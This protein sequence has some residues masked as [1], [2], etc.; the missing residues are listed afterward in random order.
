[1]TRLRVASFLIVTTVLFPAIA[2]AQKVVGWGNTTT[3]PDGIH[4]VRV[5]AGEN[6][7]LALLPNGSVVAW[8]NASLGQTSVPD[9]LVAKDISA[10]PDNGLALRLDGSAVAWGT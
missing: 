7:S 9:G 4:P 6:Y 3:A 10:A 2:S 8:G 5:E 1:M